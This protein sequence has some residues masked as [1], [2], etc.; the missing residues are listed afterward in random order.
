MMKRKRSRVLGLLAVTLVSFFVWLF[1]VQSRGRAA[2]PTDYIEGVVTS[3]NGPEAGVWVVA[4]TKELPTRFVKIV[5]TDD[6]G[7]YLLPEMP[8]ANYE[9]F[10][11][12]YGLVD[13][14]RVTAMP[15][16][17]LDLKAVVAPDGRAAAQVYPADYWLSMLKFTPGDLTPLETA[18]LVKGCFQCHQVGDE[19]TRTITSATQTLGP[20]KNTLDAW[21]HRTR[22]GPNGARMNGVFLGFGDQRKMFADWVDRIAAGEYPMQA[23]P[24]PAGVERNVVVTLWDWGTQTSYMHDAAASDVI[25]PTVNANGPVYGPGQYDDTLFWID[26]ETNAMGR[27]K[28][29]STA[30]FTSGANFAPSPYFGTA[31][32]W[33]SQAQPRSSAVDLK[34]RAWFTPKIRGGTPPDYCMSTSSNKYAKYYQ[35][36]GLNGKQVAFYDPANGGKVTEINTCFSA[37][38][39][40]FGADGKLFFGQTGSIGWIDTN[41][42]DKTHSDEAAQGWIPAVLDTNGDGKITKPWT[43][44][45]EEVDP[46]KDHRINFGCYAIGIS[47]VDESAWCIGIGALDM[48]LVRFSRGSNPPETAMAEV[49]EPPPGSGGDP[50]VFRSGGVDVDTNGVVWMNWRGSDH[51]TSFDR[52]KCKVLNGPTATGQ[53]CPEGWSFYRRQGPQLGDTKLNADMYYLSY[54]DREN[55]L[56]LGNNTPVSFAV[57]SGALVALQPQTNSW[58]LLRVPYPLGFFPRSANGR[59]DDSKAGWKG[60]GVWSSYA[61]EAPWHIEG[62]KGTLGKAVRFQVRPDPLA[63]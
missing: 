8:K 39:N 7:R 11:R 46:K 31:D 24:R 25:K 13:S 43:E 27:M 54:V 35:L 12:G 30:P 38:H 32:I 36:P 34:G 29:A 3:A 33:R 50:E 4:E 55:A 17:H 62:G 44:P 60:R 19:A 18:R 26:P 45:N 53:Q 22:S 1:V 6:R 47:P 20:F 37:D 56:G 63:K 58:V 14:P 42:Y 57:N 51:V 21:D 10:V 9:V 2:G 5:V 52:R 16:Q 59:I 61:T 28:V 15:G 23:P 49:Y 41:V 40:Q 48:Q